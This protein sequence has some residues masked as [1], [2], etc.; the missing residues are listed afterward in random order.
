[1]QSDDEARKN[2]IIL[3]AATLF[4]YECYKNYC[5]EELDEVPSKAIF[6][7]IVITLSEYRELKTYK[8]EIYDGAKKIL[9]ENYGVKNII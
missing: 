5:L 6:D 7:E 9:D 1:M 4:A 3:T 2:A 8:K